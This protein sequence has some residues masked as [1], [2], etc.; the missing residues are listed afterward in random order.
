MSVRAGRGDQSTGELKTARVLN[1]VATIGAIHPTY[2]AVRDLYRQ[3]SPESRARIAA[4][5]SDRTPA[6]VKSR[7]AS[8]KARTG[9]IRVPAGSAKKVAIATTGAWLGL[10][11]AELT[12]DVMSRR[13]INAQLRQKEVKKMG[14]VV[15]SA[16]QSIVSKSDDVD[17]G[18]GIG[19]N[20][21]KSHLV[22]KRN[23]NAEAD[24]QRRLGA[25]AGIGAGTSLV[26]GAAAARGLSV[27]RFS[28]AD[29]RLAG[30]RGPQ[31]KMTKKWLGTKAG[32]AALAAAA[33]A[34]GAISYKHGVSERNRTYG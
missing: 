21:E 24:R 4:R 20:L 34:G 22:E 6:A 28:N 26:A 18:T 19:M 8:V 11:G 2:H 5:V 12:G 9:R 30:I 33:A 3:K 31:G 1:T 7:I 17:R 15:R 29:G 13:S 25:Y 16:G 27:E 14:S 32:L 23:F 10:H